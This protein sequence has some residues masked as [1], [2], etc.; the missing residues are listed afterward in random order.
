MTAYSLDALKWRTMTA[1][2]N[3]IK[4]PQNFLKRLLFGSTEELTTEDIELSYLTGGRDMAPLV[5]KNGEAL[6][7]EGLGETFATVQTPNIRIK[8]PMTP[9]DILFTRRAGTVVF[10]TS[11]G[12]RS[13]INAYIARE[14]KRL[15]DLV[16]YAEEWMVSQA[17]RGSIEYQ[18]SPEENFQITYPRSSS[19]SFSVDTD[20]DDSS[21]NPEEDILKAKRLIADDVGL[22]P[23]HMILGETAA[24][25]FM[26][27]TRVTNL[28]DTRNYEAGGLTI[29]NQFNEQGAIYL[30][31]FAGLQVW[32]YSRS[33]NK[34]G[35]ST[36]LVRD[37]YA[38]IV[39]A[40]PAAENVLYYGAIPD[41][42]VLKGGLL[43][44]K[45]FAKSWDQEDPPVRMALVH[46]RPLPVPR[47]PDS[48]VSMQVDS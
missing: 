48:T 47:L 26:S 29:N 45:L 4:T 14:L 41:V 22:S 3:K 6:M 42:R 16:A 10:P 15:R 13:A 44:A 12:Q 28:L 19:H 1:A 7:V 24:K 5:K 38:E 37:K 27:N 31:R 35:T 46:S 32:E 23:T 39:C 36:D 18:V 8:R 43:K 25:V 17:I 30:G 21:S 33:I 11:G 40:S 20:W 2:I 34:G 9:S